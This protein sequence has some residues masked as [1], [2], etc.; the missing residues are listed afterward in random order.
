MAGL[1]EYKKKN[2]FGMTAFISCSRHWLRLN[3]LLPPRLSLAEAIK[4]HMLSF[5]W[6]CRASSPWHVLG[7]E[8]QTRADDRRDDCSTRE[9]GV[10]LGV[11]FACR[12]K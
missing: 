11:I 5:A 2:T 12:D 9:R 7:S 6:R 8:R 10:C 4:A 1:Q 3:C